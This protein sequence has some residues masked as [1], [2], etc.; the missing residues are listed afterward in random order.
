MVG[1]G[2]LSQCEVSTQQPPHL[3]LIKHNK[4]IAGHLPIK[5]SKKKV[6]PALCKNIKITEDK[7][8]F[9]INIKYMLAKVKMRI[10]YP[11]TFRNNLISLFTFIYLYGTVDWMMD[12]GLDDP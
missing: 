5:Q 7:A 10:F 6:R 8:G 2:S 11:L 4:I 1:G 12:S 9:I 3:F